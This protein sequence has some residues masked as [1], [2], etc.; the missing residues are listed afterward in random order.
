MSQ[1]RGDMLTTGEL[2]VY[3]GAALQVVGIDKKKCDKESAFC[4][5]ALLET[6]GL[7]SEN[8]LSALAEL[9][10]KEAME[11]DAQFGDVEHAEAILNAYLETARFSYAYLFL[12]ERRLGMRAMED[13]QTQ[14]RDYYNFAVT[15]N[16]DHLI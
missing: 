9:W 2:S 4:R 14:V 15:K 3:A 8:R 10:L 11:L 1:R 7:P 13:R 12:T 16:T 6:I 5:K